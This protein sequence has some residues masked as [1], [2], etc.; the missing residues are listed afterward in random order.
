MF[1]CAVFGI[2]LAG[3]LFASSYSESSKVYEIH[4]EITVPEYKTD[5]TR[6]IEA[7]ERMMDRYMGMTEM[8]VR[9]LR[10]L[11]PD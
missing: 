1:V 2:C 4:P 7:Y 10:S 3:V 9:Q 5:A 11:I 8:K 6:A